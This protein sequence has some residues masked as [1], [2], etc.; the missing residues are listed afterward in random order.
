MGPGRAAVEAKT[1]RPVLTAAEAAVL[2]LKK[3][4]GG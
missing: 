2:D 1:G 3:R 4:L